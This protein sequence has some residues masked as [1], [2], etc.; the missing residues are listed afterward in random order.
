MTITSICLVRHGET[1]WN[2]MGKIQGRTD[3]PL[4]AKG[5]L[6]A[7]ECGEFLKGTNWDVIISSP[8]KRAKQTAEIINTYLHIPL[9]EMDEF[10]ERHFGKAE[11]MTLEERMTAYPDKQYPNQEEILSVEKRVKI[12]INKI[13]EKYKD[14][15]VLLVAHGAVINTILSLFS[16]GELGYGKTNLVNACISNIEYFQEKWKVKDYNQISHLSQYRNIEKG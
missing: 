3:I 16:D 9:E 6:Q 8:L 15:K 1:D 14:G 7:K 11:G 13:H 2:V 5:I 10:V 12:G 4:N